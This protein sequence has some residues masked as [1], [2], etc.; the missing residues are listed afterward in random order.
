[1]IGAFK[2]KDFFPS[3]ELS[4]SSLINA[5]IETLILNKLQAIQYLKK[6]EMQLHVA[7]K[8]WALANYAGCNLGWMKVLPNRI[9]NYYPAAWRI[10]KEIE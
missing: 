2:G 4:L 9:N 1:M 6:Q 3:H 10:L 5:T 8:G 7:N